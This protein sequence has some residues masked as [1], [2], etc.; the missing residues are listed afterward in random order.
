MFDVALAALDDA[1]AGTVLYIPRLVDMLAFALESNGDLC[2]FTTALCLQTS[3]G[4]YPPA[5]SIKTLKLIARAGCAFGEASGR[6]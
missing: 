4:K 1:A 5:H 3:A 2:N 6:P